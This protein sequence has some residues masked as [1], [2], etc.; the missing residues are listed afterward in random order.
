MLLARRHRMSMAVWVTPAKAC[1]S[2]RGARG[3]RVDKSGGARRLGDGRQAV[4]PAT[5]AT[6]LHCA[7][8]P[9]SRFGWSAVC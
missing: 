8:R 4:A 9:A 1:G 6:G 5:Q 7:T 2:G 3:R